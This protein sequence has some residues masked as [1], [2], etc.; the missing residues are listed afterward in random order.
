MTFSETGENSPHQPV[1]YQQM[2]KILQPKSTG[3][4][5]DGTVG[6]G[7]HTAGILQESSPEGQLIGLDI[8]EQAL[9]I[10]HQ[11][12]ANFGSRAKLKKSS[13]VDIIQS[14][15]ECGWACT[16]GI[17]IDLGVSSIQFDNADRGFSIIKDAPLDMR[18]NQHQGTSAANL[19]NELPEKELARI[20]W[21]YG[22]EPRAR[23]IAAAIIHN[24]PLASTGEL[25]AIIEKVH[26]GKRGKI[27]P[28]TRT[29]QAIR[30]A[31]NDE[32]GTLQK[33]LEEAVRAL[34]PGGRLAVISFHSLEDRIVKRYFKQESRDC[35][36]PPVQTVCNCGHRATIKI[37]TKY[38]IRPNEEEIRTN[39]RSRSAKL[40]AA[41]KL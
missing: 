10:A 13:Y 16:D 28:A 6:A 36:C 1:L 20:I 34:C 39:P 4:Y 29:F 41:E 30:I 11:R 5:V 27:H 15:A 33:G 23:Q 2:I 12:I 21:T 22:E 31:V 3:R 17:V 26:V 9:E 40:R 25:A 38:P 37:I 19:V 8:D 32:L 18:F 7:G 14:I 24:R 35:I